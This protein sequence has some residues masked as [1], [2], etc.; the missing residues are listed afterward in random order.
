MK[1]AL[2]LAL[3]WT[4][5]ALAGRAPGSALHRG[6]R[7][8]ELRNAQL[9][10]RWRSST[11]TQVRGLGGCSAGTVEVLAGDNRFIV[12]QPQTYAHPTLERNLA[13]TLRTNLAQQ[14]L[15]AQMNEQDL[16]PGA[17]KG[18]IKTNLWNF[19]NGS[20]VMVVAAVPTSAQNASQAVKWRNHI[21][22]HQRL[23]SAIIDFFAEQR[24]RKSENILVDQH[25]QAWLID[26]DK[27]FGAPGSNALFRSQFFHG[28]LTGFTSA[29]ERFEDLPEDIR[30][31][32]E[33]IADAEVGA[34]THVYG[35]LPREAK[36]LKL[37]A[38]RTREIG[39][40]Q[41]LDEYTASLGQYHQNQ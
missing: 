5:A 28:G 29:Q 40:R 19:Q 4:Q 21:G 12:R 8:V 13:Q 36:I 24:D 7:D 20:E 35:L 32:V 15:A 33:D 18:E 23:A 16:V 30:E 6:L 10:E 27:T 11:P 17:V 3:L 41:A 22:E 14:R 34:L 2:F 38:V 39:L 31:V 9:D 26:P 37:H 25:G 1:R